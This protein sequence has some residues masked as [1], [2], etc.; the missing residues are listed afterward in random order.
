MVV[1]LEV[2]DDAGIA[3]LNLRGHVQRQVEN[4]RV[5]EADV[6]RNLLHRSVPTEVIQD[7][8]DLLAGN[9]EIKCL[10]PL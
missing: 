5:P 6:I 7:Q 1:G 3:R 4:G 9:M 2:V 8:E 10:K